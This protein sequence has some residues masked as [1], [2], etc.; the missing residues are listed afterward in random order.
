MQPIQ[1]QPSQ[2]QALNVP[3]ML[4]QAGLSDYNGSFNLVL[5]GDFKPKSVLSAAGSVDE[6]KTYVFEVRPRGVAESASKSLQY[7]STGNGDDT[8]ITLW[9]PADEAQDLVFKLFFTGGHYLVPIHVEA[10][11]TRSINVSDITQNSGPDVEGNIV[12]PAVHEGSIKIAGSLADNQN[13]L[14]AID[15]GIYNV[16]KATCQVICYICDG[17]F[18]WYMAPSSFAVDVDGTTQLALMAYY[19][20]DT[21][22][23]NLSGNAKWG[24][25][26]SSVATVSGGTVTGIGAGSVVIGAGDTV[27]PDY[28]ASVCAPSD[29]CPVEPPSGSAIVSGT[30]G[31]ATP[32]I[33]GI[34]PGNWN[35]G[36]TTPVTINGQHFG[37]N[38]PTLNFSPGGGISYSLSNYGDTQIVA[39]VTV[40]ASTPSESVSVSVTNN[41]YN[42]NGFIGLQGQGSTSGSANAQVTAEAPPMVAIKAGAPTAVPVAQA[43]PNGGNL[44]GNNEVYLTATCSPQGNYQVNPSFNWSISQGADQAK[45]DTQYNDGPTMGI[46]GIKGGAT[47]GVTVSV[48]CKNLNSGLTSNNAA[49]ATMTAQQPGSLAIVPPDSTAE[50]NCTVSGKAGC[51]TNRTFSY[52]VND[53][54]GNAIAVSDLDFWDFI[55]TGSSNS[56]GISSYAVTCNK[57]GVSSGTQTGSCGVKTGSNGQ[58]SESLNVCAT[59]CGSVKNGKCSGACSTKATQIWVVNGFKITKSLTYQCNSISVQ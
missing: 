57:N 58:F 30:V 51:S 13:V 44:I 3:V 54:N 48:T 14:V 50:K 20:T 32:V 45:I 37:N 6:T 5:D 34:S 19:D 12:P 42:G 2:S 7:W 56:C 16:R 55:T 28:A 22:S 23:Y 31:D 36:T 47:N 53:T 39:N 15:A 21:Y 25:N 38:A 9:N 27:D 52:Q 4:S 26:N 10:R 8:M 35:A 11:A 17:Y 41:G 1:L 40:A 18:G 43:Q 59:A 29:P 33:S 49:T 24:T 46:I